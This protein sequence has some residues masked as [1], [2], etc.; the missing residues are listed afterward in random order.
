[1]DHTIENLNV[2]T[3]AVEISSLA[4]LAFIGIPGK[5]RDVGLQFIRSADS[6]GANIAEGYGRG[7]FRDR[8]HF[9]IISRG[10]L[11]ECQ[12]WIN[13]LNTRSLISESHFQTLTILLHQES[14]LIMGY[15]KYLTSKISSNP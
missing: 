4:W 12:Y 1:M 9:L 15:I 11:K 7:T 10:S 14:L 3:K 6:I 2:Y 8:K 13:L 5:Y